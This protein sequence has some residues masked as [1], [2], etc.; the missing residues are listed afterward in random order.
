MSLFAMEMEMSKELLYLADSS[1][2]AR[3]QDISENCNFLITLIIL[4]IYIIEYFYFINV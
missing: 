3:F 4:I 2:L 1:R